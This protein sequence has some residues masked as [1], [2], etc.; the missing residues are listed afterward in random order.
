MRA[1]SFHVVLLATALAGEA[2]ASDDPTPAAIISEADLKEEVKK[3]RGRVLVL[4]FW[5]TWCV[6]CLE[7]V[8]LISGLVRA[9]R[10]KGVDILSVSLD[11][12]T[13]R[14]AAYVGRVL[15]ER[16]GDAMTNMILRAESADAFVA[17][18]DPRWDGQLPAFFVYDREGNLR[19]AFVGIMT[20][21]HFDKLVA[22]V[23][24]K[25]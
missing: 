8:P 12:P 2:R 21:A 3:H 6:P 22:D 14:A 19:R 1:G 18:I 4:H 5:A 9:F 13:E 20:R 25:K 17:R 15:R 16:Q 7:E 11:D 23:G 10:P 24:V